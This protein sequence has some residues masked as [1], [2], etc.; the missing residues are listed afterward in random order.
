MI[1]AEHFKTNDRISPE[2]SAYHANFHPKLLKFDYMMGAQKQGAIT[3]MLC[4][5]T[6]WQ[7]LLTPVGLV[8]IVLFSSFPLCKTLSIRHAF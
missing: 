4:C 2:F 5:V 6:G 3:N 8:N 1:L 7:F